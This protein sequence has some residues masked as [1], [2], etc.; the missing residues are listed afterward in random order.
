LVE[1]FG[2]APYDTSS[3]AEGGPISKAG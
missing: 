1:E 3:L 2:L